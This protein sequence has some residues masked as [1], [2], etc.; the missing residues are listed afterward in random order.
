M[1]WAPAGSAGRSGIGAL[2]RSRAESAPGATA[3]D[4]GGTSLTYLQLNDQV[5]RT[6]RLL[7]DHGVGRGDRVAILSENRA[8]Y[9]TATLA[10]AKLGAI[11]ACQ[12]TR[13]S[14]QELLHCIRL[15]DPKV[16][17]VSKRFSEKLDQV[18][19]GGA[20]RINLDGEFE[21]MLAAADST[22]PKAAVDPEDGLLILYTSGTTGLPKGAVISHRAE[23]ARILLRAS[24][25]R[26][27][28]CDTY[29]A[30]SPLYHMTAIEVSLG[31]LLGGGKVLVVDGFDPERLVNIVREERL[32]WLMLLPG[33][34][35]PL[36]TAL[37]ID[38][39]RPRGIAQCG[40]M[41][42]LV[43]AHQIA[44]ITRLLDAPYVNTFGST[45]C[46]PPPAS[47]GLIPVGERPERLSKTQSSNCEIR[48]VD[49]DDNDVPVGEPGEVLLR[50]P[51]LFSGYYGAD[52]ENAR[53][54]RGGWFHTGDVLRRNPD[55]T[56]DF[57]DRV[58][59]LIK[60]GGESIYPAEIERV[61]LSHEKVEDAV[62]VRRPDA[63]W[64]EV[65]VAFV[66][67]TDPLVTEAELVRLCA[68]ELA[69]YRR[70]RK[71]YFVALEALPRSTTGKILRGEVE[72]W[73]AAGEIPSE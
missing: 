5:N 56:L 6:A 7:A 29:V 71:V 57:V 65:P 69:A 58:R 23:L 22:E 36:I 39:V 63:Q 44:E 54:F 60:S 11:L 66:A 9:L 30:W 42:D 26:L 32:G 8:A 41:A 18:D 34:I 73:V 17:F 15:V 37:K 52:E 70:P 10:A 4:L 40:I 31:A 3:L 62:V 16:V 38:R 64:G 24:D 61:L 27:R 47:A 72:R 50:G 14:A 13:L 48:L 19:A 55:G 59:Y 67:R 20:R 45:E 51:T 21:P 2:F 33:M 68:R 46:G 43:P 49:G 1:A 28:L 25:S 12:N 53:D 35:G